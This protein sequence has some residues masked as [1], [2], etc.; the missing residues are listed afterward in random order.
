MISKCHW[1]SKKEYNAMQYTNWCLELIN[2]ERRFGCLINVCCAKFPKAF[3]LI[4]L[5]VE[6][7]CQ[8][9][10]DMSYVFWI[11]KVNKLTARPNPH[12]FSAS[13]NFLY[14]LSQVCPIGSWCVHLLLQLFWN[15]LKVSRNS[16]EPVL[17]LKYHTYYISL[18]TDA[19]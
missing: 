6:R 1:F 12:I 19:E 13:P 10:I 15:L 3:S 16:L 7:T 9:I 17:W 2:E 8:R 5:H 14:T 18:I 11:Y 4:H